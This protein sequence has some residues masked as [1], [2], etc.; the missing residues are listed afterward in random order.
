MGV[1]DAIKFLVGC[2]IGVVVCFGIWQFAPRDS[3]PR[4]PDEEAHEPDRR[5]TGRGFEIVST[6]ELL[7]VSEDEFDA[8][9]WATHTMHFP[10]SYFDVRYPRGVADTWQGSG[11]PYIVRVDGQDC[12]RGF[13]VSSACSR[14]FEG[15]EIRYSSSIHTGLF[16]RELSIRRGRDWQTQPDGR[17]NELVR[18]ALRKAGKLR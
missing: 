2:V 15:T 18:T 16:R 3:M 4:Y 1:R 13:F 7:I 8:Y 11:L 9:D 10:E 5:P 6:N 12:Y 14:W 17:E